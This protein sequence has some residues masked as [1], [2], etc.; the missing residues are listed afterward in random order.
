[1]VLS[2]I[3]SIT[4]LGTAAYVYLKKLEWHIARPYLWVSVSVF[5]ALYAVQ[6]LI[7]FFS[8]PIVFQGTRKMLS[9]RVRGVDVLNQIEVEHLRIQSPACGPATVS[10]KKAD[11]GRPIL[12]P[13]QYM[14]EVWYTR[15]SNGGKSVLAKKHDRIVLGHFGTSFL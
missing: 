8:G 5:A 10:D 12:I 6:S 11:D 14:L 1:M 3:G 15:T 9:N 4:M 13:P 2:L 7:K